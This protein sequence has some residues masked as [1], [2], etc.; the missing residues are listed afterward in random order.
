MPNRIVPITSTQESITRLATHSVVKRVMKITGIADSVPIQ[1]PEGDGPVT[2]PGSE[3]NPGEFNKF[4]HSEKLTIAVEE[5]FNENAYI[6]S[7]VHEPD[8]QP[9]FVDQALKVLFKPVYSSTTSVI[10]FTYR[11]RGHDT[12]IRWRAD[13]KARIADNRQSHLH[14]LNYHY[15]VPKYALGMLLHFHELRENV[16]GYGEAVKPWFKRCFTERLR[17]QVAGNGQTAMFVIAEKQR[18]VQGWFEF[19]EPPKEEKNEGGS[20]WTIQ[21]T[22][23]FDYQKPTHLAL[24]YPLMIHNQLINGEYFSEIPPFSRPDMPGLAGM[25]TEALDAIVDEGQ[26][27]A[28]PLGGLRFP[29]WDEWIPEH[30]P[31]FTASIV[32]WMIAV[33][34]VDPTLV[35]DL[36]E[37]DQWTIHPAIAK[38]MRQEAPYMNKRGGSKLLF[39]L[40]E[41]GT[42]MQDGSV[43]VGEDLI[44]R[45]TFAMNPRLSYHLRLSSVVEWSV[46]TERARDAIRNGGRTMLLIWQT[47]VNDLDVVYLADQ[48]IDNKIIP[49]PIVQWFYRLVRIVDGGKWDVGPGNGG[50]DSDSGTGLT[51]PGPTTGSEIVPGLGDWNIEWRLVN[52][53]TIIA[54]NKEAE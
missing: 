22:Y 41:D 20:S 17:G 46:F 48:L 15:P 24:T 45:S 8:T 44:V 50:W 25:T 33:D 28:D 37:T 9:I 30:V 32:N 21:F 23:R 11:A 51:R 40:F 43:V 54:A 53:V 36:N 5:T 19:T 26:K 2:Q 29:E 13:I 34:P 3:L 12:A 7:P 10:T 35:V 49:E 31:A 27:P 47:L 16:A 6:N 38:F 18:R 1:Y 52:Y 4:E 14:E 39:T 42:P